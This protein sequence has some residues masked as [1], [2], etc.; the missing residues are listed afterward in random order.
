MSATGDGGQSHSGTQLFGLHTPQLAAALLAQ[1]I[2]VCRQL[3]LLAEANSHGRREQLRARQQ[4][5]PTQA[6]RQKQVVGTRHHNSAVHHISGVKFVSSSTQALLQQECA[7]SD[8]E[9][10]YPRTNKQYRRLMEQQRQAAA[11]QHYEAGHLEPVPS[12]RAML[13]AAAEAVF[14]DR[15]D[16]YAHARKRQASRPQHRQHAAVVSGLALNQQELLV[17]QVLATAAAGFD[18]LEAAVS[19][20]GGCGR[21]A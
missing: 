11:Q 3:R 2:A 20:L 16:A 15:D 6:Q 12:P 5:L 17:H 19:Q 14:G 10:A 1:H 7:S 4:Q 21:Y 9:H 8:Y 18:V 13:T